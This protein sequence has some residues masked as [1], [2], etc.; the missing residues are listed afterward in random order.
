MK[1]N[2]IVK[3]NEQINDGNKEI[4]NERNAKIII[5]CRKLRL[6]SKR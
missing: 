2:P 5:I 3:L 1:K 6:S 4:N